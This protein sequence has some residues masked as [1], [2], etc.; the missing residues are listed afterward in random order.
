MT[1]KYLYI[2]HY[3]EQ[4]MQGCYTHFIK[5]L[6]IYKKRKTLGHFIHNKRRGKGKKSL[7]FEDFLRVFKPVELPP[8]SRSFVVPVHRSKFRYDPGFTKMKLEMGCSVVYYCTG[9]EV[10]LINDI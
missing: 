2:L 7:T 5:V 4:G 9:H 3:D 8:L 10:V 1:L 6:I